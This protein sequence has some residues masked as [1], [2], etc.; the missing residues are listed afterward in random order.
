[1]PRTS[2]NAN[3]PDVVG[4]EFLGVGTVSNVVQFETAPKAVRFRAQQSGPVGQ[5]AVYCG[6]Q[7]NNPVQSLAHFVGHRTPF[8]VDLYPVSGFD[9]SPLTSITYPGTITT[10]ANV[11]DDDGSAPEGDELQFAFDGKFLLPQP[12]IPTMHVHMPGA[13]SFPLGVHVHSVRIDLNVYAPVIVRRIDNA[14]TFL[15]VRDLTSSWFM[16]ELRIEAGT[17]GPYV[18]WTPSEIRQF[19]NLSG[20]R[21]LQMLQAP[22]ITNVFDQLGITVFYIAEKRAGTAIIEPPG[23]WQWVTANLVQPGTSTPAT[24]TAGVEYILLCR[25]AGGPQDFGTTSTWDMSGLKDRRSGSTFVHFDDL[26]WDTY[27]VVQ[28]PNT[29]IQTGLGSLLDGLTPVRLINGTGT[30]QTT[31]TQPYETQLGLIPW[32]DSVVS[33]RVKQ[34]LQVPA[35]TTEY[36]GVRANVALWDDPK[37]PVKAHLNVQVVNDIGS[38]IAGPFKLTPEMYE[39]SPLAGTTTAGTDPQVQPYR[40]VTVPFGSGI[41]FSDP[42][43]TVEFILDDSFPGEG[44]GATIPWRIGALVSSIPPVT[45]SDQTSV[46]SGNGSGYLPPTFSF[47][48]MARAG[49]SR[50]DLQVSLLSQPPE[51]VGI[52]AMTLYQSVTGGPCPPCDAGIV[53]SCTVRQIAYNQICWP[54]TTLTQDKFGYYELQRREAAVSPDWRTV[55]IITPT[56]AAVSGAPVT[57][58]PHCFDDWT[59][60]YD[61][62]VCYRVRQQ[63]VDGTLSD[64]VDQACLTT[65]APT[66]AS[67]FITAQ[68]D[69][70]LNVAFPEVFGDRLPTEREWTNLDADQRVLRS[71]YGRDHHLAF[72]PTERLGLRWERQLLVAAMCT[73][74]GPSLDLVQNIR[75]ITAA[76]VSYL[77]VRDREGN[78]WYA[79]VDVPKLTQMTDPTIG[80]TWLVDVVVTELVTPD[81]SAETATADSG[82]VSP[83]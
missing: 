21:R 75:D 55:A 42:F 32:W 35:G 77:V 68:D 45:G 61:S 49:I 72:R 73:P 1:M 26:D 65:A 11:M 7:T 39:A 36:S 81:I 20:N 8:V 74:T 60:V 16:S 62:E 34:R 30:A 40:T 41:D 2:W 27:S 71:V 23:P 9:A 48:N 12:G 17:T 51:I 70:S 4:L 79:S 22:G 6:P 50:G 5:I 13:S 64:F 67:M 59:H 47:V 43:V 56:G 10:S 52:G 25:P 31:D 44:G 24:V 69:P 33:S 80:D 3:T 28:A 29:P 14:S 76:P 78:R 83:L 58:V 15:W 37:A 54:A 57:G 46:V 38:V 19:S 63:R 66:G 53:S 18:A 82:G